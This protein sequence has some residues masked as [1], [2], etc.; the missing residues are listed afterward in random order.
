M[1]SVPAQAL[2][3]PL[4]PGDRPAPSHQSF[5]NPGPARSAPWYQSRVSVDA[6]L[7]PLDLEASLL[8]YATRPIRIA[9]LM[10]IAIVVL[11]VV[12]GWVLHWTGVSTSV[13]LPAIP[14]AVILISGVGFG[15]LFANLE[16]RAG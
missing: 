11:L 3:E 6:E 8:G 9:A 5:L 7:P 12:P 14:S 4:Y 10:M 15:L 16:R 1:N 2:H 13:R